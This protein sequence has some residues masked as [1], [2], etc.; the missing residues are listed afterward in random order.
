MAKTCYSVVAIAFVFLSVAC[1]SDGTKK[2]ETPA[3]SVDSLLQIRY[4][5]LLHYPVDSMSFPRS[6]TRSTK[7]T[8]KVPSKDWTSGFFPGNLWQLYKLTGNKAYKERA[9]EWTALME[10]EKLNG[11]THDMGFKI[12]CSFGEGNEVEK[13]AF[14]Q[15]VIVESAQT[16]AT[17]FNEN[18]GSLRSWDFNSD[19]WE[20]PVIID[21]MMNLEL[22]FEAT[23][24]SGDSAFHK[25]AVTHANTTLKNHFRPDNSSVHVVVYDTITGVVKEKVTHQG[26]DA[27]SVWSRGQGW[28]IYGYTMCYRFTKDPAYLKQAEA[29]AQFYLNHPN[30][31][32]DG[33]PFWD[34]K[35][36]AL[37]DA[38]KD[39]SAA[40]IIASALL[41][42]AS[43]S[44]QPEY[45][46]YAN[47]VM[48]TLHSTEYV[49]DRDI[50]APFILDHSTGN[51]PKKDEM[52]E[53]I[54]YGD[55]YFLEALLRTN[56]L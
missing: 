8:R 7:T 15:D 14:Y 51:W 23:R 47:K 29:S 11:K 35:D 2:T 12:Y 44:D 17:R 34:L 49:L 1:K 9:S 42:L 28:G 4:Q 27:E 37:P 48:E 19:V 38:V 25:M 52:D 41:E 10:K 18:V 24:I 5:N 53:P 30:L 13:S 36:P 46:A 20:F 32:E 45:Q 3:I 21:N 43:Y 40:T 55:Y 54:V 33:I 26:F 39:V 31:P 6:Y 16:L 56:K 22:L 50:D